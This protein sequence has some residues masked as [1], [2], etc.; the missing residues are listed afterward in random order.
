[1]HRIVIGTIWALG[2]FAQFLVDTIELAKIATRSPYGGSFYSPTWYV[3]Q[4]LFP[5]FFF[6]CSA[7]GI[8]LLMNRRWG[9]T[10]AKCL[11]PI[12]LLYLLAYLVFGHHGT[13][14]QKAIPLSFIAFFG[15]TLYFV[16]HIY[17]MRPNKAL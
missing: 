10:L 5:I 14:I 17:E 15:Y 7:C 1:M 4:A 9:G 13:I 3:T 12:A 2:G 16:I 6:L 11:V 8:G